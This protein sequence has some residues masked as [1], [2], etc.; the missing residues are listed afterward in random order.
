MKRKC[1]QTLDKPLLMFGLE[2][3]DVCLLGTIGG[4]GSI[5]IGPVIPGIISIVGWIF[6]MQFKKDKPVGYL[7]H[8]AYNQGI[9]FPGLI[10]PIKR[11]QS[12]GVYGSG[13]KIKKISIS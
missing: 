4:I 13:N 11:V 7:I 1:P 12:Y 10:P 9:C 8:W 6:L 3:E 2:I 5:L